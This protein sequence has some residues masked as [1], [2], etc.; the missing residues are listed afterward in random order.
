MLG[1]DRLVAHL[2]RGS[3]PAF[4][5][6]YERYGAR[7]LAFC[8]HL[9]GSHEEAEDA[10]QQTFASAYR[11]LL[12]DERE[13]R[14]KPW[15]YTIARN[16]C[17]S[18]LRARREELSPEVDIQVTGLEEQVER[19]AELRQLLRDLGDL[20][21]E[22]R[23]ALLLSEAGGLAHADVA[24]V[25]GCEVHR[26]KALVFRARSGLMQRR[27]ARELP[28][29]EVREQ[30][31]NLR[32][33]SLRRSH[34]RHHLSECPGCRGFREEVKRQRLL[35]AAALPVTPSLGLK[36]SVL[37]AAGF[38]GGTGGGAAVT[39]AGVVSGGLPAV[40]ATAAKIAVVGALVGGGAVGGHAA[41]VDSGSE[42]APAA[43]AVEAP[44]A[45]G[46][47]PNRGES[48]GARARLRRGGRAG[49]ARHGRGGRA[50][51]R[52]RPH[53]RPLASGR[54]ERVEPG[55]GRPD[56]V[57][58]P[59]RARVRRDEQSTLTPV[60]RRR[61][62]APRSWREQRSSGTA[63]SGTALDNGASGY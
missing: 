37:S 30:L 31:A 17:L 63:E 45:Q 1:D 9:L 18:V 25:L 38:G 58:P 36:A 52:G 50:L 53:A 23:A 26:V 27:E 35:L 55:A 60:R 4:E 39:G 47:V 15:L 48:T 20:P 12:R 5:V 3:E 7:I 21:E 40:A 24:E 32:G 33:G 19:R 2:R 6:L 51:A 49:G 61:P 54:S 13:I 34:L 41:L 16:R 22:Q 14:L 29:V 28:C 46:A 59:S 8:R 43:P 42:G 11:D 56:S 62:A 44:A 10:V 57:Q